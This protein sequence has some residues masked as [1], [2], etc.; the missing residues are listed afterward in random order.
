MI[1][2]GSFIDTFELASLDYDMDMEITVEVNY[3]YDSGTYYDDNGTGMP[4]SFDWYYK[5]IAIYDTTNDL[6]LD[7]TKI[8]L[9]HE[10]IKGDI[11]QL[12]EKNV[13]YDNNCYDD[14]F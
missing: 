4:P 7:H 12:L 5:V 6:H 1:H 13:D 8:K 11:E 9:D 3:S 14:L 2:K 10:F